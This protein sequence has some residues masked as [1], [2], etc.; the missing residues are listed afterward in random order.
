MGGMIYAEVIPENGGETEIADMSGGY[1]TLPEATKAKIESL[2]A[3]HS[4]EYSNARRSGTFPKKKLDVGSFQK[5][6]VFDGNCYL[7]PLV[8]THPETGRKMLLSSL[9][10]FQIKDTSSGAFWNKEESTKFLDELCDHACQHPRTYKHKWTPGEIMIW[11]QRRCFHRARPYTEARRIRSTRIS[12][13][14]VG[15][16]AIDAPEGMEQLTKEFEYLDTTRPWETMKRESAR[17]GFL[18]GYDH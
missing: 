10:A 18:H 8:R 2:Q 9:H 16:R 6:N 15:D 12:G 7:R 5:G 3:Y 13:D 14:P 17:G 4:L 11:D 1:D